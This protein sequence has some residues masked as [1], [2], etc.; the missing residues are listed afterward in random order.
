MISSSSLKHSP[1][2]NV[3]Y[4]VFMWVHIILE[5]TY[6]LEVGVIM[7]NE[8]RRESQQW[9]WFE[10]RFGGSIDVCIPTG[11]V[12]CT[13]FLHWWCFHKSHRISESSTKGRFVTKMKR[14]KNCARPKKMNCRCPL[15]FMGGNAT[16]WFRTTVKNVKTTSKMNAIPIL[17]KAMLN[18][19]Q[20]TWRRWHFD[21]EFKVCSMCFLIWRSKNK[22]KLFKKDRKWKFDFKRREGLR[23]MKLARE[24]KYYCFVPWA[25][26]VFFFGFKKFQRHSI[27]YLP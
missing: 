18:S 23:Y 6:F 11:T 2:P 1:S 20:C 14:P 8:Q 24:K 25:S 16:K 7:D 17:N 26:F 9:Q 13:F 22:K 4:V 19:W 12:P 10:R 5:K 21:E 27:A 15:F 3:I